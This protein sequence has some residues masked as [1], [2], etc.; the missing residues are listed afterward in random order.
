MIRTNFGSSNTRINAGGAGGRSLLQTLINNLAKPASRSPFLQKIRCASCIG[1]AAYLRSAR[2]VNAEL[3]EVLEYAGKVVMEDQHAWAPHLRSR[4]VLRKAVKRRF[5][6]P[7]LALGGNRR[8]FGV[9]LVD[10]RWFGQM[11]E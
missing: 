6:D 4:A 5:V 1:K 7:S 8:I 9:F 2:I 10:V 3:Q 11:F